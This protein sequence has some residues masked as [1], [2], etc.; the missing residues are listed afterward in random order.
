MGNVGSSGSGGIVGRAG[1][2]WDLSEPQPRW[3]PSSPAKAQKSLWLADA[4]QS[5][6]NV[7][8]SD[9]IDDRNIR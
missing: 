6:K 4:Q 2:R 9:S 8:S 1:G 7:T 3:R 5:A